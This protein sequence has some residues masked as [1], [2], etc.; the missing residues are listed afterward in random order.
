MKQCV[1]TS[2]PSKEHPAGSCDGMLGCWQQAGVLASVTEQQP[3]KNIVLAVCYPD[4]HL[5]LQG[6]GPSA[7]TAV[8]QGIRWG[9]SAQAQPRQDPNTE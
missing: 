2:P 3:E 4:F 5:C 8:P 6:W 7:I 9:L 1:G